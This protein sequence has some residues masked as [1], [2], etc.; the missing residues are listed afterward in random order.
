MSK[1]TN[2]LNDA[3]TVGLLLL[4]LIPI[5]SILLPV[6]RVVSCSNS[7]ASLCETGFD[8]SWYALIFYGSFI[9]VP[10]TTILLIVGIRKYF[11]SQKK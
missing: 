7:S 11:K 1:K 10:L 9:Y 6:M 5:V 3:L 4:T 2:N 8:L